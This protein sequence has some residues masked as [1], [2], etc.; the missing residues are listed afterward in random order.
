MLIIKSFIFLLD[1]LL[2]LFGLGFLYHD[3]ERILLLVIDL[4]FLF[5]IEKIVPNEFS[6]KWNQS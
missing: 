5:G 2:L 6:D 1:N 3:I 4:K